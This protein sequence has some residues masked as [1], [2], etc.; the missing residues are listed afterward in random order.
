MRAFKIMKLTRDILI[1]LGFTKKGKK[2]TNWIIDLTEDE[3]GIFTFD[4]GRIYCDIETVEH[5]NDLWKV[6]GAEEQFP[7][8]IN[9]L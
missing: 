7:L 1:K 5:L 2:W 9:T 6:T 8:E 3:E 4:E